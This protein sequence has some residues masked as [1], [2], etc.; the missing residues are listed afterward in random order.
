M[1]S[2]MKAVSASDRVA[3]QL[4]LANS[5]KDEVSA[6]GRQGWNG[7][8]HTT[9]QLLNYWFVRDESSV[10]RFHDCQRQA[11]ETAIYCHEVLQVRTLEELYQKVVPEALLNSQNVLDEVREADFAKYCLKMATGT[12]KTWVLL[13]LLV[14]QY[15]NSINNE[16]PWNAQG[17]P[18]DWYSPYFLIVSPGREVLNR[19]LDAFKGRRREDQQI[20]DPSTSDLN[21]PIF[22]PPNW[23]QKFHLQMLE[24]ED[25]HPNSTPPSGPFIF[26]TN[27]QQF[28]MRKENQELSLWEQ[29]TGPEGEQL[30]GE[31]LAEYLSSFPQMVVMNDEAHHV[32][33]SKSD[34]EEELVWRKFLRTIRNRIQANHGKG[35]GTFIQYD[36]SA[37]PFF[38]SGRKKTFFSHIIYDY[39]LIHAMQAMLV[40]QL[41]LEKRL[42][43]SADELEF[44]ARR[45]EPEA[46]KRMGEIIGLSQGQLILLEIGRKKLE[47]LTEEFQSKGLGKKPVMMVLCEETQV[48]KLVAS[49]FRN[50]VDDNGVHYDEKKVLQIHTDLKEKEL[51]QARK[52]LDLIDANQN[53]LN[54]VVSVLMLREGFDRKNICII[55]VLRATESDLL[56]EQIVG[57]G[58]RLMFQ[59]EAG[60]A[61]W[62]SK[63]EAIEDIRS[64]RKPPSSSFD[65]LFI[66]EHPRFDAFYQQLRSEGYLIGEGDTSKFKATGDLLS[67][68]AIPSRIEELDI[69]WPHQISEQGSF[70][71]L[72]T[73]DVTKLAR[74]S[75]LDS[76]EKLREDFGH[77]TI[78]E[79]HYPTGRRT[80][81]WKFESSVFSYEFFL[82]N[83]SRAVA[84][85]GRTPILTG[86]LSE[87]AELIDSYVSKQLFGQVVD[88]SDSRNCQV[89]N[90]PVIFDHVIEEVRKA[91][92]AKLGEIRY[93]PTG[94]WHK[95]SDVTRLL[96][97]EKNSIE[98]WRTIYPRQ[99]FAA[100]GGGFER[101]FMGEVLEQSLEVKAYCKLDKK[102]GLFIPYRDEYGILRDYEVDF[103]VKT[104]DCIYL[105]ETKADKDLDDNTVLLK[106]KAGQSWCE[107]AASL[108]LPQGI[109]QPQKWE[110]LLLSEGMFKNNRGLG[111]EALIPVCRQQRDRLIERFDQLMKRK[112]LGDFPTS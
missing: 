44:R 7:A 63:V 21:S 38:G 4:V 31:F 10:D 77:L 104:D 23:R 28:V 110:Y 112:S 80:Q 2:I 42:A 111:F 22:M 18:K 20:R 5:L 109:V 83:A 36:F 51:E 39:D 85:A 8:T 100:M 46:G 66:V 68:D 30:R 56:L 9:Q 73:I 101:D 14:W 25:V 54:V 103:I 34:I 3:T 55:V 99:S 102:H 87:I 49:H 11:I 50:V 90:V 59:Q 94:H 32:H 48:A 98:T 93:Q 76:F 105:V 52:D 61:I 15:F 84:E 67:I 92:L 13:A 71:D 1:P 12:G 107:T 75:M 57:R 108:A 88:Y 19:L 72:G 106:A 58:L 89:L 82:S 97:R 62:Q 91:I 47:S 45:K 79:M 69:A 33:F 24:P 17:E 53:P 6:W 64:K 74:Y 43:L 86:H 16:V 95:L 70:P 29:M 78:Q 37:T 27:W 81:T 26:I 35:A 96:M 60:D 40:K 41:F 65:F